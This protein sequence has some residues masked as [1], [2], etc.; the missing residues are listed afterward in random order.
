MNKQDVIKANV[1][2]NRIEVLERFFK[3][4]AS[5]DQITIKIGEFYTSGNKSPSDREMHDEIRQFTKALVI[6]VLV[7]EKCMMKLDNLLKL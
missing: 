4:L 2:L 1:L 5:K 6:K 3:T 7:I